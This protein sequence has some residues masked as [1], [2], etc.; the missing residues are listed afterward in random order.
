MASQVDLSIVI[1]SWNVANLLADCLDSIKKSPLRII[2]DDETVPNVDTDLPT[3]EV[4]IVDSASSDNSVA[5][6]KEQYDWVNLIVCD[7]NIGFVRGTNLGT[8]HAGGRLIFWLNPDT[9]LEPE[10]IPRLMAV[11]DKNEAVGAVGPHTLNADGSHQSTRRRF[12]TFWTAVFESTWLESTAPQ[13]MMARF[14]VEDQPD[15]GV[16]PVGWVQGSA[17]MFKRAVYDQIGGFDERYV[18]YAEEMDWCKRAQEVGWQVYYVGDAYITHFSGQSTAQVKARSHVHFQHSKL[19]YF[20]RFHGNG[21]AVAL[22]GVLILNYSWQ[23]ILEGVKWLI[24]HRRSLRAE[25]VTT[26]W[27]VLKSLLWAGENVKM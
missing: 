24:G 12:P 15:D 19:R 17:L 16:Y 23:L 25:R 26:Y 10:A 2:S 9:R 14:R 3:A 1:V 6:L 5:M 13:G 18:M 20:Q 27:I 4:I 21:A 8:E 11:L 7:E 22:R